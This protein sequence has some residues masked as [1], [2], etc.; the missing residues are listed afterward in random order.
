MI[1]LELQ[2]E[3]EDTNL[4]NGLETREVQKRLASYG[5]NEVPEKKER[6]LARLGKRFWGIVPWMLEAT[7]FI[8][9]VLGK[10]VDAL[11]ILGLLLFNA[12][13]SLWRE[14]KA[15]AAMGL[16]KQKLRI[17]S[18]VKRDG[19]WVTIPA[20]EVVPGDVVRGRIG[21]FLPADVKIVDGFLGLG[22]RPSQ[23]NP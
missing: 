11:V 22:S 17:Q 12:G 16:L 19:K 14:G 18:R 3:L 20:R 2:N 5:Y 23:V 9:L 15:K 6:F 21:D 4:E 10:Y 1:N 13:M 7:T 8:T